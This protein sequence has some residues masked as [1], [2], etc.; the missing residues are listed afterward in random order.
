VERHRFDALSFIFGLLFVL[1][2]LLALTNLVELTWFD[3]RWIGPAVLVGLGLVLV[4]TAGRGRGDRAADGPTDPSDPTDS[5]YDR[6]TAE[7]D[8]R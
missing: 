1:V 8:T 7:V 4:L 2:A 5:T 6:D 3:L